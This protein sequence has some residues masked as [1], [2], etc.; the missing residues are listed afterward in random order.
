MDNQKRTLEKEI[1]TLLERLE[2][3]M[4]ANRLLVKV[5]KNVL[6]GIPISNDK[7]E[8]P[9]YCGFLGFVKRELMDLIGDGEEINR[10][11]HEIINEFPS[12]EEHLK[13][14]EARDNNGYQKD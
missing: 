10:E 5:V 1:R 14:K 6:L 2:S 3:L 9:S 7:T 11:L 13:V 4:G 12:M 8:K